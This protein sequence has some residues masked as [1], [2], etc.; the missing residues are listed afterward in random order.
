MLGFVASTLMYCEVTTDPFEEMADSTTHEVRAPVHRRILLLGRVF[1][2]KSRETKATGT[3][4]RLALP[5]RRDTTV[6]KDHTFFNVAPDAFRRSLEAILQLW[7]IT[8]TLKAV[9]DVPEG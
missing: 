5:R 8:E 1:I 7:K 3:D 4:R 6:I 2:S 9:S